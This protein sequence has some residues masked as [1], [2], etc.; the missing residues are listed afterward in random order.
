MGIKYSKLS[1]IVSHALR[2]EPHLYSLSLDKD[3]WVEISVLLKC[4]GEKDPSFHNLSIDDLENMITFSTKKRH[5]IQGERI[6]ARYGHSLENKINYP[7]VIPPDVLFHGTTR[8][9]YDKIKLNSLEPMNRQY[10][11]LSI[12]QENANKVGLRKTKSPVILRIKAKEA[13]SNGINFY[14]GGEEIYLSDRIPAIHIE[15]LD[16]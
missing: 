8:E 14:H 15:T 12:N 1:K 2:H 4:L 6:R 5:E 10:V 3:G 9:A 16:A 13:Y 7:K 11:H